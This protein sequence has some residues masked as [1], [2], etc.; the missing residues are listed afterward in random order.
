MISEK[1]ISEHN[2]SM[3]FVREQ[4][5]KSPP[6]YALVQLGHNLELLAAL[7]WW[8]WGQLHAVQLE[9]KQIYVRRHRKGD[10][11]QKNQI[12]SFLAFS[13]VCDVEQLPGDF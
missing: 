1:I 13:E 8:G 5:P 4:Q 12:L 11:W 2:P 7:D 10:L 6:N 3:C 9:C